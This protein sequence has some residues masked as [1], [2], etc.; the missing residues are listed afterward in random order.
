MPFVDTQTAAFSGPLYDY[1]Q[2]PYGKIVNFHVSRR[3]RVLISLS[4]TAFTQC[5]IYKTDSFYTPKTVSVQMHIDT[6]DDDSMAGTTEMY[7]NQ[8]EVHTTLPTVWTM[9][10]LEPGDHYVR[11]TSGHRPSGDY[12]PAVS[13]DSNDHFQVKILQ[14]P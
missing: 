14:L 4:C 7:F 13:T 9:A 11:V 2:H 1:Y 5:K 6:M 12:R 3:A 8:C 10:V